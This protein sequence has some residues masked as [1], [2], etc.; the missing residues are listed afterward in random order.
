VLFS[1]A[2]W[3]KMLALLL[4]GL[5]AAAF[6]L[7][8]MFDEVESLGAGEDASI[9]A[10][11]VTLSLLFLWL[12]VN[13]MGATFNPWPIHSIVPARFKQRSPFLTNIMLDMGEARS[14]ATSS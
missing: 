3:L 5:N 8:D 14:T 12:A 7:T 9:S 4:L 10:K 13:A 2:F 6:Y 11:L 1:I